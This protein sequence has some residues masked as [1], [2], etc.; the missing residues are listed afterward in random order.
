[1]HGSG[2]GIFSAR[3]LQS[4]IVKTLWDLNDGGDEDVTALLLKHSGQK[5]WHWAWGHS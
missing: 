2:R 3:L 4:A 1:M 5:R